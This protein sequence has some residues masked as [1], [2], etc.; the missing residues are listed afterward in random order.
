MSSRPHMTPNLM[1]IFAA[2]SR[3]ARQFSDEFNESVCAFQLNRFVNQP[4]NSDTTGVPRKGDET[5][6]GTLE[7]CDDV[8][9][10]PSEPWRLYLG[11]LRSRG[12]AARRYVSSQVRG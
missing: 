10:Y 6:V 3:D 2:S 8:G 11:M 9:P 5:G 12:A 4:R 7:S 1:R